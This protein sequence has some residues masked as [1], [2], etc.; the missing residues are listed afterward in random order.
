MNERI[1]VQEGT[2]LE[3][4]RVGDEVHCIVPHK[5]KVLVETWDT[6]SSLFATLPRSSI[7][8]G[9]QYDVLILSYDERVAGRGAV[10]LAIRPIDSDRYEHRYWLDTGTG[11]P[12]RAETI[13]LDG[14]V[15]E[16]LKFADIRI[17]AD[18]NKQ[19]TGTLDVAR[20]LYLVHDAREGIQARRRIGMGQQRSSKGIR[21]RFGEPQ[22]YLRLG[23]AGYAY[24]VQ[25]R[26]GQRFSIHIRG[27]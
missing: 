20:G 15:V 22:E 24:R 8:P 9:S 3:V 16:Q 5:K 4:I 6:A 10:K 19:S 25:R 7:N 2:P 13:D 18:I 11:F 14:N 23:S 21:D 17:A 1:V 26:T 12:L 27:R